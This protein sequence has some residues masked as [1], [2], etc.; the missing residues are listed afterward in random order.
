MAELSEAINLDEIAVGLPRRIHDVTAKQ[1][2]EAPD[3][4]ALVENGASW[5]YRDLDQRVREIAA[6][7]SSFGIT[8]GDFDVLRSDHMVGTLLPGVEGRLRTLDGIPLS[9]EQVGELHVR[10][11]N[12]MRGYCRAPDLTGMID[13]EGWFNTGYVARFDGDCLHI[14]DRTKEMIGAVSAKIESILN[15]RK[16]VQSA[17][18]G[19][20]LNGDGELVAFVQP[21]PGSRVKATHLIHSIEPWLTTY[22]PLPKIVVVDVLPGSSTGKMREHELAACFHRDRAAAKQAARFQRRTH[23]T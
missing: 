11:R 7:L 12:V 15:S 17:V 16:D 3:R 22:I 2:A 6:V 14:L 8:A 10:G 23:I 19:R 18:I 9:K 13:G 1:V 20:G 21:S 4:I 5:S